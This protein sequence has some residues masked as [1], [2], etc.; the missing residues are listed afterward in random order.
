MVQLE[1][2]DAHFADLKHGKGSLMMV[3]NV[4]LLNSA[5]IL[6]ELILAAKNVAVRNATGNMMPDNELSFGLLQKLS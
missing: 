4:T 6:P 5:N 3:G 2:N 1:K